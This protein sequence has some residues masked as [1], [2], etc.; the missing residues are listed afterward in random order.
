[1]E[2]FIDYLLDVTC[3]VNKFGSTCA[4]SLLN[5]RSTYQSIVSHSDVR[6]M[7]AYLS[8]L[9]WTT[10]HVQLEETCSDGV[11]ASVEYIKF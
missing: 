1:M 9:V 7:N 8:I 3:K 5:L 11:L 2:K 4:M 6:F 10:P